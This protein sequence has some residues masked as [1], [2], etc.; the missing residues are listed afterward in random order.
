VPRRTRPPRQRYRVR[1][2]PLADPLELTTEEM[3]N[4]LVTRG[5]ATRGILDRPPRA[6][7]EEE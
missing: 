7:R 3:A 2:D 4:D 6:S 5:L 1:V